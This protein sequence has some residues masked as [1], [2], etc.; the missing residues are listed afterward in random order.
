LTLI[1]E[2]TEP[3]TKKNGIV[4]GGVVGSIKETTVK[5]LRR[6]GWRKKRH[7]RG[8]VVKFGRER[9]GRALKKKKRTGSKMAKPK[10]IRTKI[11]W[12]KPTRHLKTGKKNRV[13]SAETRKKAKAD[14]TLHQLKVLII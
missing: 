11:G 13:N 8:N 1:G 14:Q 7:E 12:N 5:R 9:E 4:R 2:D 3:Q 6:G 10:H